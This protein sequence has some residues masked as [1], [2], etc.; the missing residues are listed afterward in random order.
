[1]IV[2]KAARVIVV[3]HAYRVLLQHATDPTTPER[4]TW[5]ELPGG[6]VRRGEDPADAALRELGEE[7]GLGAGVRMGPC[8]WVREARFRFRGMRFHQHE[9]VYVAWLDDPT[10]PRTEVRHEPLEV[11]ALL[12]DR[13]WTL[14]EL[15]VADARFYPTRLPALM[16]A[17]VRGEYGAEPI[18]AGD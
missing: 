15:A 2:R 17:V 5:W 7:T 11:G 18:D 16:P 1:V 6:G 12:G 3:D 10:A 4:G 13:W 14:D 9:R 8:V